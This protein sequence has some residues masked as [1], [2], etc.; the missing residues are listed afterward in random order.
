MGNEK[1]KLNIVPKNME[2]GAGKFHEEQIFKIFNLKGKRI[3][4][5][6]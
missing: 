4:F 5:M 1:M 3:P 6:R 2:E